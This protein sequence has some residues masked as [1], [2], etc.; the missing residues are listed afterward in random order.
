MSSFT[1]RV[2]PLILDELARGERRVLSLVVAVRNA[3]QRSDALRGNLTGTVRSSLR[4]LTSSK[5]IVDADGMYSLAP[6][7]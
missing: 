7:K 2:T 4:A 5:A 1:S 6:R 3:L